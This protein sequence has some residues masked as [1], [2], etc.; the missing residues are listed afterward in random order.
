MTRILEAAI[1]HKGFSV[2]EVMSQ[3][4]TY[5]GRKNR[6]GKAEEMLGYFRD[7]AVPMDKGQPGPDQFA[8]GIFVQEERPEY[9]EAYGR[10]IERARAEAV[11]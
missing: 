3:C 7:H 1:R 10:T 8:V 9:C 2:V 5:F 11:P 4:P 6:R